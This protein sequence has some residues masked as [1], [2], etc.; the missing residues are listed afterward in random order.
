MSTTDFNWEKYNITQEEFISIWEKENGVIGRVVLS[1]GR[2][3]SGNAYNTIRKL[4]FQAGLITEEDLKEV[5]KGRNDTKRKKFIEE[6][7]HICMIC[8][9]SQWNNNH[10]SL[11]LDHID[12]NQ[13]NEDRNNL[14]LLCPN[15]HSQTP[16]HSQMKNICEEKYSCIIC[17][18]SINRKNNS[19]IC[20][21]CSVIENNKHLLS[22]FKENKF[23]ISDKDFETLWNE[24]H[25][26]KELA[27]KMN[28]TYKQTPYIRI[29]G[30]LLDLPRKFNGGSH[31][32]SKEEII[33]RIKDK[34][35]I[36][37]RERRNIRKYVLGNKCVICN[38]EETYNGKPLSF[39]I[40]HID[41][42]SRNNHID[43]L[44]VLCPNCHSQTDTWC[45]ENSFIT[46]PNGERIRKKNLTEE[47]KII[48]RKSMR[49]KQMYDI[50]ECGDRKS[51]KAMLC[52]QCR[53]KKNSQGVNYRKDGS[54][55]IPPTQEELI[56]IMKK[57]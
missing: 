52:F 10:I 39:H 41:G 40:D 42:N 49:E 17:G 27:E 9:I 16:T 56:E 7:D 54:L 50:C 32:P 30:Y 38:L 23:G 24:S 25:S 35:H 55:I 46:M 33:E 34:E 22:S 13:E 48:Y 15:C 6:N 12:G 31:K 44:R 45:S 53:K 29:M 19:K 47:N 1:T 4:S 28:T 20:S 37:T 36:G 51:I 3:P 18:N 2:A 8:G 57:V 5:K 11:Q 43:N 14:R 21:G 26:M